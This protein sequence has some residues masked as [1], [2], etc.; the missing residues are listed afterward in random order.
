MLR[1]RAGRG[2]LVGGVEGGWTEEMQEEVG[3]WGAGEDFFG[4]VDGGGYVR[5]SNHLISS[6]PH[7]EEHR[8]THRARHS[9]QS[10]EMTLRVSV[11]RSL[12]FRPI[13]ASRTA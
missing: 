2:E 9:Q 13:S 1:L 11:E 3:R 6:S 7:H 4:L 5:I 12:T 8:R 10:T